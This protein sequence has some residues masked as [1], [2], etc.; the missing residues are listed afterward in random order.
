MV[1]EQ[2]GSFFFFLFLHLTQ[3][4]GF[5]EVNSFFAHRNI[6]RFGSLKRLKVLWR[7]IVFLF[8]PFCP[9]QQKTLFP[10]LPLAKATKKNKRFLATTTKLREEHSMVLKRHNFF[11]FEFQ[12]KLKK[13]IRKKFTIL[14]QCSLK[15]VN[16]IILY[17]HFLIG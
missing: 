8:F 5:Q 9:R 13:H 3:K 15:E 14:R 7:I 11:L 16:S 12:W 10:V 17:K 4:K 2:I 6:V 1:W